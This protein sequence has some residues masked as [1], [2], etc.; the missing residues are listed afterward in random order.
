MKY[1][2]IVPVYN[3]EKYLEKCLDSI[4]NQTYQNYELIIINDGSTDKSQNIIN[5]YKNKYEFIKAYEKQNTGVA[6]TRNYGISK[7]QGDYIIFVDS[8]DY[9]ELNTLEM[10][11]KNIGNVDVLKYG[12]SIVTDTEKKVINNIDTQLTNG[13]NGFIKL[14][15]NKN[16]FDMPCGYAFRTEYWLDNNFKFKVGHL[17]ED[18][19]LIPLVILKAN[20]FVSI[21]A[22]LYNYYMSDNSITRNVNDEQLKKK[23]YD[24]LYHF[25]NLYN[26]VNIMDN[27]D[28]TTKQVFN[29]YI[30]NGLILKAK[31]LNKKEQKQYIKELKLRKV[32]KLVLSNTLVRRIK[33]LILSISISLYIKLF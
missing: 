4:I 18:F 25:D 29:S 11:N 9:I 17:H 32:N 22:S 16:P 15:E 26:E 27:I 10:I 19:G 3:T 28:N 20:T 12:Y 6:D 13:S 33:K 23:A 24:Y 14:C 30:S 7:V 31:S 2:I 1:S 5:E 21:N 8:D